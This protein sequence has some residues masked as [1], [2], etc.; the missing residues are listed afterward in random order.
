[1]VSGS[2]LDDTPGP[3]WLKI[4]C[5]FS[6]VRLGCRWLC[7]VSMSRYRPPRNIGNHDVAC[8]D[9]APWPPLVVTEL[10]QPLADEAAAQEVLDRLAALDAAVEELDRS[11]TH[12]A[13]LESRWRKHCTEPSQ[14][15]EPR[16]RPRPWARRSGT[17]KRFPIPAFRQLPPV[18]PHLTYLLR[19]RNQR[20][21]LPYKPFTALETSY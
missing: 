9:D 6:V 5:P 10:P 1:M 18:F 14:S 15:G 4:R 2:T 11:L 21:T 19:K 7:R 8:A 16:V 3:I 17:P 20:P 12:S 13:E